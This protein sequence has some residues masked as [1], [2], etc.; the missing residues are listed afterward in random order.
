MKRARMDNDEPVE[1]HDCGFLSP[2]VMFPTFPHNDTFTDSRKFKVIA[3]PNSTTAE[4]YTFTHHPND[5]GVMN[6]S[7]AKIKATISLK[8]ND[9]QDLANDQVLVLGLC[10]L[11]MGWKTREVLINNERINSVTSQE[12]EI[13]YIDHI[14]RDVLSGY[15]P[16]RS[17]TGCIHNTPGHADS[18]VQL[19]DQDN[20]GHVNKGAGERYQLC[21]EDTLCCVMIML[22]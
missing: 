4:E 5:Y 9:G 14:I 11:R 15:K 10:P 6:L 12:N 7:E 22:I 8:A 21:H 18:T 17:I 16:E 19:I 3:S 1:V 2:M 20:A 13:A